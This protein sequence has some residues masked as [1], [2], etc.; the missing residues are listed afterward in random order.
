MKA[1]DDNYSRQTN[2]IVY[3]SYHHHHHHD[4]MMNSYGMVYYTIAH[5]IR[6]SHAYPTEIL[7]MAENLF[8]FN[9]AADYLITIDCISRVSK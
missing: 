3:N 4:D 6:H 8:I 2:H 9:D 1:K 7:F 5:V